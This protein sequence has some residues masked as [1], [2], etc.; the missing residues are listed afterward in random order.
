MSIPSSGKRPPLIT[1]NS[2]QTSTSTDP[3]DVMVIFGKGIDQLDI[4]QIRPLLRDLT[5]SS[6]ILGDGV[7]NVRSK[8]LQMA[9]HD[10]VAT[11]G[12]VVICSHGSNNPY[13]HAFELSEFSKG[14][15]HVPTLN[16]IRWGH[17]LQD[18]DNANL[19]APDK[20]RAG[21]RIVH[22]IACHAGQ[23][24]DQI[25]PGSPEWKAGYTLIYSDENTVS[26][27]EVVSSLE[28]ALIYFDW[29]KEQGK[30]LDPLKLFLLAAKRQSQSLTL[31]GGKL[32]AP[33]VSREPATL[34]EL[35]LDQA[36]KRIIGYNHK[37]LRRLRAAEQK[38]T[39]AENALLPGPT[40]Q[41]M[42]M[43]FKFIERGDNSFLEKAL[44]TQSDLIN[45]RDANGL[46]LL[47]KASDEENIECI[48]TLIRLG[49]ELSMA[50]DEGDTPLHVAIGKGNSELV[51]LLLK[52]GAWT[53]L[54]NE[55][56]QSAL[57]LAEALGKQDIVAIINN[58]LS[59]L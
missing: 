48:K 56:R 29:C 11:D 33:L 25:E 35:E 51:D 23:V 9:L 27:R 32:N 44:D 55:N 21:K 18:T 59:T 12:Q 2:G 5:V 26:L 10:K 54:Q 40:D 31:L 19:P 49:A 58:H 30:Q 36:C 24:I 50:D 39:P 8:P 16:L 20:Q 46:N 45:K 43:L 1:N 28:T 53:S 3:A 42:E 22:L 57:Q 7:R 13:Q 37:D 52:A 38:L 47:I 34:E 17:E 15:G 4:K 41:L 6:L 14:Y